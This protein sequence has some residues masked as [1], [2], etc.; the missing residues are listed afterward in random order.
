MWVWSEDKN[1]VDQLIRI[2][3]TELYVYISTVF[4]QRAQSNS[5]GKEF[6][7]YIN[8]VGIIDQP[9]AQE[10]TSPLISYKN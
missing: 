10:G 6:F 2:E 5:V 8:G 9:Y 3:S 4:Q 1:I 7:L